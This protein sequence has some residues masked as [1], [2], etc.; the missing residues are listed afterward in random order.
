LEGSGFFAFLE[1][2]PVINRH[3]TKKMHNQRERNIAALQQIIK[4]QE[5]V[6]LPALPGESSCGGEGLGRG[7]ARDGWASGRSRGLHEESGS[8]SPTLAL[9][10]WRK[11]QG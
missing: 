4:T 9:L 8:R 10:F 5:I 11:I 7:F 6:I 3:I 1:S 2:Q